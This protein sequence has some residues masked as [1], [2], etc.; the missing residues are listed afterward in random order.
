M[1]PTVSAAGPYRTPPTG[2]QG[3]TQGG[4]ATAPSAH[5]LLAIAA[6]RPPPPGP[7][8]GSAPAGQPAAWHDTGKLPAT[9][10]EDPHGS[11]LGC[12]WSRW[13]RR[14]QARARWHHNPCP[15]Q[16]RPCHLNPAERKEAAMQQAGT[17]VP[18]ISAA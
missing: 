8:V 2:H 9:A 6:A 13:R 1:A 17:V 5:A 4:T 7:D 11:Q 16:S 3:P 18:A 14:H 15:T 10:D 12:A